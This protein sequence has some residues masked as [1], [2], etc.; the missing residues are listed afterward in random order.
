MTQRK[1][2]DLLA[3]TA[4]I[5]FCLIMGAQ[6]TAMKDIAFDLSPTLQVAIRSSLAACMI[7]C[8]MFAKNE[9]FN[10]RPGA[11]KFALLAGSFMG[12]EF[13][14]L[15]K[16]LLYTSAAHSVVFLYSAPIFTALLLHFKVKEERLQL[17]Q[18]LG[19]LSAFVGLALAFL[20]G[21]SLAASASGDVW[22]GDALAIAAA[23]VWSLS[24][25]TIR[26]SVLAHISVKQTLFFQLLAC[27][28][29]LFVYA[30]LM[31]P[32]VIHVHSSLVWNMVFQTVV[33]SFAAFLIWFWLLNH[34]VAAQ[35]SGLSFITPMFGVMFGVVLLGEP[36]EMNFLVGAAL[37]LCGLVCINRKVT[38]LS[39][40]TTTANC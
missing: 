15:G 3:F 18:W 9:S 37:V 31:E 25:V 39:E 4:M 8:I 29:V 22:F 21:S 11:L 33:V 28:V 24:T 16:A 13:L 19:I 40:A 30:I 26:G 34:Y 17:V 7:W 10:W 12:V 35:I 6:Q 2:L 27:S 23:L 5:I 20:G 1:S 32:L 14:L 38:K 36:L